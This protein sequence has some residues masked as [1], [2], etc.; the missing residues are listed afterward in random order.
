M[1]FD[2]RTEAGNEAY[3]KVLYGES[4]T[5]HWEA[6]PRSV[7]CWEPKLR[8]YTWGGGEGVVVVAVAP[9]DQWGDQIPLTHN[10]R[11]AD[12]TGLGK[13]YT[14]RWNDGRPD[15]ADED[16]PR[17]AGVDPKNPPI[18]YDFRLKSR[19]SGAIPITVKFF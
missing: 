9:V 10:G 15:Q 16:L 2:I 6:D 19:E 13:K 14:V 18:A 8:A 17:E 11:K 5:K 4:G 12:F 3:A 7:A 1:G